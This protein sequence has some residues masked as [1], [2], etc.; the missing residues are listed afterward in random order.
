[1]RSAVVAALIVVAGCKPV[2]HGAYWEADIEAKF[3]E[4]GR[5]AR[6][7]CPERIPLGKVED[8]HFQCVIIWQQGRTPVTVQLDEAGGWKIE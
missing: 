4:Q 2:A 8:N 3:K 6:V 5:D 1:M 7:E